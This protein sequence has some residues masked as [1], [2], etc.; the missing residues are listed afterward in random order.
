[1]EIIGAN[2]V[3]KI[4]DK[5][6]LKMFESE[7]EVTISNIVEKEDKHE[8]EAHYFLDNE[9]YFSQFDSIHCAEDGWYTLEINKV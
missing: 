9:E 3:L 7:V 5:L 2:D 4:G 1:M 6:K 8:N